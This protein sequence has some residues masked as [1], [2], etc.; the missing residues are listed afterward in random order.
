MYCN[1]SLKSLTQ[2]LLFEVSLFK[3]HFVSALQYLYCYYNEYTVKP[4][5]CFCYI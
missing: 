4:L 1:E 5:V 3:F 2:Q